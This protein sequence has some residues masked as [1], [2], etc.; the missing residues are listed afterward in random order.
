MTPEDRFN[1]AVSVVLGHEGGYTNDPD[2]PGGETNFGITQTD[3]DK[4]AIELLLLPPIDIKNLTQIEAER[5]YK[6]FFWDK[7][8]YN[9]IDSLHVATKIFDMS[10][11]MGPQEAHKLTQRALTYCGYRKMP[12]DGVL[13]AKTLAA[14]NRLCVVGLETDLYDELVNEATWFYENLAKEKPVLKKFLNGWLAR[15]NS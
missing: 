1:Q 13:G 12:I 9:A 15:A 7:Y 2:D 5:F 4:H 14:I 8:N 3:L 6:K 10:V 11:D